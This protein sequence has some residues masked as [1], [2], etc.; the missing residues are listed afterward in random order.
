LSRRDS[1]IVA[2]HE[3]PGRDVL[4]KSTVS[5]ASRLTLFNSANPR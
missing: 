5:K 4:L 1:T 2:W 3:V